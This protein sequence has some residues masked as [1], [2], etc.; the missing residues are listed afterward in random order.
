MLLS[1]G[2]TDTE[3]Q[4]LSLWEAGLGAGEGSWKDVMATTEGE[5]GRRGGKEGREAGVWKRR[6]GRASVW[7]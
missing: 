3:G 6:S 4:E 2:K 1:L 7:D 5:E